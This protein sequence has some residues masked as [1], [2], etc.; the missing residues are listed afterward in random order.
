M[1]TLKYFSENL[2]DDVKQRMG[3]HLKNKDHQINRDVHKINYMQ[4][5]YLNRLVKHDEKQKMKE[6]SRQRI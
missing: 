1:K 2:K 5:K 6:Y 4:E 3:D